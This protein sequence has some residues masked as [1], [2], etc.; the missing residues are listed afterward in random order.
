M[1]ASASV[2]AGAAGSGI[3]KAGSGMSHAVVA[4]TPR[5]S[6]P[7]PLAPCA[8]ARPAADARYALTRG[9]HVRLATRAR[10]PFPAW[11]ATRGSAETRKLVKMYAKEGYRQVSHYTKRGLRTAATGLTIATTIARKLDIAGSRASPHAGRDAGLARRAALPQR[12]LLAQT[13]FWDVC[14]LIKTQGGHR[15]ARGTAAEIADG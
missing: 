7:R 4:V 10:S 1:G 9:V 8:P 5:C 11:P 2:L 12:R 13:Q 15:C 3:Q 6:P 14:R